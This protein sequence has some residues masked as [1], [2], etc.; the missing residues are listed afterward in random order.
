[1]TQ[2]HTMIHLQTFHFTKHCMLNTLQFFRNVINTH[3]TH[4]SVLNS[5]L[6]TLLN[7]LYFLPR[8]AFITGINEDHF[9]MKM[10]N[11]SRN[12][13][14]ENYHSKSSSWLNN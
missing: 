2:I 7:A 6:I 14:I 3:E 9:V 10:R 8:G 5:R 4:T 12:S 13:T 11:G 1:M